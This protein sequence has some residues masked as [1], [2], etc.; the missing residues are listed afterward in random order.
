M[1]KSFR[2]FFLN[3]FHHFSS[4]SAAVRMLLLTIGDGALAVPLL[5]QSS[6]RRVASRSRSRVSVHPRLNIAFRVCLVLI[7]YSS[8]RLRSSW[9]HRCSA[10]IL[11]HQR[12]PTTIALSVLS[13]VPTLVSTLAWFLVSHKT[14]VVGKHPTTVVL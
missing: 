4:S 10:A 5:P 6:S 13:R 1:R 7:F 8:P 2:Q 3:Q 12:S 11:W 9:F 14:T